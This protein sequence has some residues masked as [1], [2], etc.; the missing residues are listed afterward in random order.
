MNEQVATAARIVGLGA[1]NTPDEVLNA[2]SGQLNNLVTARADAAGERA[3][4]AAEKSVIKY[5]LI[6][7]GVGIVGGGLLGYALARKFR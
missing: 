6:A 5:S 7:A 3:A 4:K 1:Y 2:I